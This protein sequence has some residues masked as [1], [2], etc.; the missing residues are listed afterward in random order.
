MTL[1]RMK[2]R[3]LGLMLAG[4][5]L[6]TA[7]LWVDEL[8]DLPRRLLDGPATPV[9]RTESLLESAAVVL[10]AALVLAMAR[11]LFDRIKYLEGFWRICPGCLRVEVGSE[12]VKLEQFVSTH[13]DASLDRSF[14]PA[15]ADEQRLL[16]SGRRGRG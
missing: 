6:L 11:R 5:G 8:F 10:V 1:R 2:R 16:R 4:F 13:T 7:L 14:C 3:L 9:N 15:C 12:W